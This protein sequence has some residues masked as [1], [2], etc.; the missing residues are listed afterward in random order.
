MRA[1][2][3]FLSGLSGGVFCLSHLCRGPC[4]TTLP[5]SLNTECWRD[6]AP[7]ASVVPSGGCVLLVA[8][9]AGFCGAAPRKALK[10]EKA[11][12]CRFLLC[13]GAARWS[14]PSLGTRPGWLSLGGSILE[15]GPGRRA[16][17]ALP[18]LW[19]AALRGR[20]AP[21]LS[22]TFGPPRVGIMLSAPSSALYFLQLKFVYDA[23]TPWRGNASSPCQVFTYLCVVFL[24]CLKNKLGNVVGRNQ[25]SPPH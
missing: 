18:H 22:P 15:P 13:L 2:L 20:G 5:A 19:G 21:A 25:D 4:S 16:A 8:L 23:H 6:R 3:V 1:S 12:P 10:R 7:G 17:S 24:S 14:L 9:S 11:G